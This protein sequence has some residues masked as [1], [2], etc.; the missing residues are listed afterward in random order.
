M[1]GTSSI[2]LDDGVEDVDV[3]NANTMEFIHINVHP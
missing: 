3:T 2:K 1:K